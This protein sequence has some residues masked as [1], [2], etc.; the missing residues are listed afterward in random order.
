MQLLSQHHLLDLSI[1]HGDGTTTAAKKGGD[2]LGYSGHKHFK[3]E[4]IVAFVD[5][6][7]NVVSPFTVA[8][9]N[10]HENKLFDHAFDNLKNVFKGIGRTLLGTIISLDSA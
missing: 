2:N 4:K 9:G 3:G 6:N 10:R 1:L 7:C 8:P 5:R